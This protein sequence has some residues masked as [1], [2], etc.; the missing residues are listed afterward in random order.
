VFDQVVASASPRPGTRRSTTGSPGCCPC[1]P[2]HCRWRSAASGWVCRGVHL[3]TSTDIGRLLG[4]LRAPVTG[5]ATPS[6]R[7]ARPCRLKTPQQGTRSTRGVFS[8]WP[9]ARCC[10]LPWLSRDAQGARGRQRRRCRPRPVLP[11]RVPVARL[12]RPSCRRCRTTT[13]GWSAGP[14]RQSWRSA[15]AP[16]WAPGSCSTTRVTSSPTR[17]WSARTTASMS[18]SLAA[19]RLCQPR[20]SAPTPPTTLRSSRS[21]APKGFGRPRSL[22]PA[23]SRSATSSWPWA[24]RWGCPGA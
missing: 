17:M 11:P 5:S 19:A 24:V 18:W 12:G 6:V 10:W 2:V 3:D 13:P 7:G 16:A 4:R 21:T 8:W 22:I 9:R 14:C 1:R 23:S 20:L 15:P